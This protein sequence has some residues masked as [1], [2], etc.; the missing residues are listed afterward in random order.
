MRLK[1]VPRHEIRLFISYLQQ[2]RCFAAHPF[3]RT[4]EKTLSGHTINCY[5]RSL[6]IFYSWL[7]SEEILEVNPF[8]KVKIPP[9]PIKVIP[10]FS[11]SQ[12]EQLLRAITTKTAIGYRNF[13]IILTLLDTGIR[14]SELCDLKM[15]RLWLEDGIAK[16]IG[17]RNKE[18]MI[19]I[20]KQLQCVLWHYIDRCRPEPNTINC[21]SVFL[22]KQGRPVTRRHSQKIMT[23]YGQKAK[24]TGIRCSPHTLRHTAA[25]S[26]LRNGGDVFSLQR[27]LGHA[28]LEMTRRYCQL[29]DTDVKRT[30]SMAS[31]VDN[32]DYS[33]AGVVRRFHAPKPLSRTQRDTTGQ[34]RSVYGEAS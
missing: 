22:T 16:V 13:A 26:F 10:A 30:H 28:S 32:L 23:E 27:L 7:V 29:A 11:N 15:E 25:I 14:I 34:P 17:K 18:R 12:I 2:T 1:D 4:Q 33:S 21:D 31:P 5:L 8:V 3:N 19:P 24:L 9:P 6:R 20:G